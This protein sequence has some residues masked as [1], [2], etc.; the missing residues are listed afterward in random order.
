MQRFQFPKEQDFLNI[1]ANFGMSIVENGHLL[2]ACYHFGRSTK[3][4][5]IG[6]NV[7]SLLLKSI[8]QSFFTRKSD[9]S[10]EIIGFNTQY[11]FGEP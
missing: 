10:K 1:F 6:V 11:A 9:I 5:V 8:V 3:R 2:A 7:T 4:D